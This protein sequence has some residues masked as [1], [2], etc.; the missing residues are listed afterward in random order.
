MFPVDLQ[1][2]L[3]R[4]SLA[5]HGRE[6]IA[7]GKR[8]NA[9]MERA[10]LMVAWRNFIKWRSERKPDRRTPA[11]L[12]GLAEEPWDWNRLLARR[13][14][15]PQ[16]TLPPEWRSFYRRDLVTLEVGRNQRH[17]AIYAAGTTR[18]APPQTRSGNHLAVMSARGHSPSQAEHSNTIGSTMRSCG[19][20][21]GVSR[22]FG[23]QTLVE[24][25]VLGP[26]Y[27]AKLRGQ[28][29]VVP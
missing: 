6:T 3:M 12:V 16:Q 27:L 9:V 24:G 8:H 14:F 17:R 29:L 19:S 15:P 28:P 2:G 21:G 13:L 23:G 18:L 1:H 22:P 25:R 7:F 4:H 5:N 26:P 10:F 11:M 20:G